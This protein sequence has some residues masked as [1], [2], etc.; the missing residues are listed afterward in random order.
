MTRLDEIIST[1]IIAIIGGDTAILPRAANDGSTM[2]PFIDRGSV[3]IASTGEFINI[4]VV[5]IARHN[6]RCRPSRLLRDLQLAS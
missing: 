3:E 2:R 6:S 4:T 5:V 1:C